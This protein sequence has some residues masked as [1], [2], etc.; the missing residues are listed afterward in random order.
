MRRGE[1][2]VYYKISKGESN[3]VEYSDTSVSEVKRY[4]FEY[5][6]MISSTIKSK[7][8]ISKL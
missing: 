6:W 5:N 2:E 3:K 8:C 7:S 4:S 1:G